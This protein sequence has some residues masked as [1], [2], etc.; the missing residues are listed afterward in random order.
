MIT[1][2]DDMYISP[3]IR[4]KGSG[5]LGKPLQKLIIKEIADKYIDLWMEERKRLGIEN[6]YLFV[7]K[8]KGEYKPAQESTISSWMDLLTRITGKDAFAHAY[9]HYTALG[10]RGIM[11][12]LTK[13]EIS[14]VIMIL[15]LQKYI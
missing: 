4:T 11:F 7:N 14:S 3:E 10:S 13:L 6:D 15:R 1:E 8:R 2:E 5:K 12:L 9:R